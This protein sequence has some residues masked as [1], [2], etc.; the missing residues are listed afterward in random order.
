VSEWIP[1]S[2][3]LPDRRE[4][5]L[6]A[7]FDGDSLETYHNAKECLDC[8]YT[9]GTIEAIPGREVLYATIKAGGIDNNYISIGIPPSIPPTHWMPL[10]EPPQ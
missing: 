8:I 2:E 9:I 3:R 6:I 4:I 7:F 10:K 5:V 1:V